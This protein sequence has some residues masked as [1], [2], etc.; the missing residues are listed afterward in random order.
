[1][2]KTKR[3]M[4]TMKTADAADAAAKMAM[5]THKLLSSLGELGQ[6]FVKAL[7]EDFLAPTEAEA[8]ALLAEDMGAT[9]EEYYD[10]ADHAASKLGA[11]RQQHLAARILCRANGLD[12]DKDSGALFDI[13]VS[14]SE[15]TTLPGGHSTSPDPQPVDAGPKTL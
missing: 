5:V 11:E 8:F 3:L 10:V 9:E 4:D 13:E 15:V 2:S 6:D 14:P 7:N 12:P 1:M